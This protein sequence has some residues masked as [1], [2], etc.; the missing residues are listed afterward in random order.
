MAMLA[1]QNGKERDRKDWISLVHT[2][3]ENFV[4]HEMKQMPGS[5]LAIIELVWTDKGGFAH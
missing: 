3:D 5:N 2:A 4:I 1:L